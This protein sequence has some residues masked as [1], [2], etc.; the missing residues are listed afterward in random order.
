MRRAR[1][2]ETPGHS[3]RPHSGSPDGVTWRRTASAVTMV[4]LW[5]M[6]IL[7]LS[8]VFRL[9]PWAVLA[10]G[11]AAL[12]MGS[13]LLAHRFAPG[14]P[15]RAAA[16]GAAVGITAWLAWGAANG[17][18]SAWWAGPVAEAENLQA[19]IISGVAPLRVGG[20][21]A[22]VLLLGVVLIASVTVLLVLQGRPLVAGVIATLVL[23]TPIAV[24]GFSTTA[25]ILGAAGVPLA[26]LAWLGSPRP[27]PAGLVTVG[28]VVALTAVTLALAPVGRDRVWNSAVLFSPVSTT[29]PDVTVALAEDLRERSETVAFTGA[30]LPPGA[31]RF[32]LATLVDFD[33]GVWTPQFELNDEG[34]TVT[35]PRSNWEPDQ[36][37]FLDEGFTWPENATIIVEGLRSTW[38]PIPQATIAVSGVGDFDVNEWHWVEGSATARSESSI[39][40]DGDQYR[41][42]V[43]S[44]RLDDLLTLRGAE[45]SDDFFARL[46]PGIYP[47]H[48][49]A[50]PEYAQYLELPDGMPELMR[51]SALS[52]TEGSATALEAAI[53]LQEFF[54]S[55]EFAYDE[56]APYRPGADPDDPYAVMSALL[57]QR[58]GFCVHY[59]S[60]FAVMARELGMPTRLAVGY[61]VKQ[62]SNDSGVEV[63]GTDLHAWPEVFIAEFGWLAFEPT[64][65]GAGL[66][67]DRNI[68]VSP[69]PEPTPDERVRPTPTATPDTTP[70]ER[71]EQSDERPSDG[72]NASAPATGWGWFAGLTLML[73]L[74]APAG[75]RAARRRQRVARIARGDGAGGAAWAELIDTAVDLGAERF[76]ARAPSPAPRAHTPAARIEFLERQGRL[77]PSAA[78]AAGQ[79]VTAMEGE[80]YGSAATGQ[81]GPGSAHLAHCL[82]VARADLRAHATARA[83]VLAFIAPR[84]VVRRRAD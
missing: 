47:H 23:L 28:A 15:R 2:P 34:H 77:G 35:V 63:R 22:D 62:A 68:D 18:L 20:A 42:A 53:A 12:P 30:G 7:G 46:A 6:V 36:G 66:R 82:G 78:D 83:R 79:I 8:P 61:A 33:G 9:G 51:E 56:T 16:V 54:R 40:R 55:G 24:T 5:G 59:A 14:A 69:T 50:P 43:N 48:D 3:H 81:P 21:I 58:S 31:H 17:R 11:L 64:P 76:S 4:V 67:A 44:V 73:A 75:I 45:G 10:W 80:R 38:L 49:D 84:S 71:L 19:R 65:G 52:A 74:M 41:V 32:T 13:A 27:R 25:P 29:V 57:E 1:G 60:T 37:A 72:S 26:L 70:F 39:T